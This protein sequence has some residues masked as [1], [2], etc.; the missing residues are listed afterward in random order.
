ME[1]KLL[2]WF[3]ENRTKLVN[4]LFYIALTIELVLMIVEKSELTFSYESYVFRVTFLLT[5]LAVLLMEHSVAEW[6]IIGFIIA[7]AGFSYVHTGRNDLLRIAMFIMASRDIDLKKAL[8]YCF[9]L[10]FA[11][12]LLI[13]LLGVTGLLGDVSLTLDYG[14]DVGV[15][16]RYVFGFGHPNT[17][18]SSVYA[19]ILMWIGIYG[20]TAG[21]LPYMVAVASTAIVIAVAG[22]RT[23]MLVMTFTLFLAIFF[24]LFKKLSEKRYIYILGGAITPVL[25]TVIASWAA[26]AAGSFYYEERPML[27]GKAAWDLDFKLNNRISNLYYATPDHGGIIDYWTL[28]SEKGYDGYFDMGW[29]RLFYWYGIIPTIIMILAMLAIVY[30]CMKQRDIWT[31][32]LMVSLGIYTLVEATFVTRYLGRDFFL[33]IA[34][35]YLGRFFRNLFQ[36]KDLK[37]SKDLK[38]AKGATNA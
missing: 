36:P 4:A 19:L 13:A 18:F 6:G 2:P 30:E 23:G 17:L 10:S 16:T 38:D 25:C 9:Y 27:F 26:W 12:F 33:L 5:L 21:I 28:F 34:G 22:T 11:G 1:G 32:V 35:V 7:L 14:R 3:K 8:K 20:R 15:E 31:M 24:R 29:N 37:E